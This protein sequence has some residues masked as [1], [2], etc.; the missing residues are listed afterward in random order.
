MADKTPPNPYEKLLPTLEGRMPRRR[1]T[2]AEMLEQ[3]SQ[4][5]T[6]SPAGQT[7]LDRAKKAQAKSKRK[8]SK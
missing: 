6:L 2:L 5:S 4:S 1:L 7:I 8:K 3:V